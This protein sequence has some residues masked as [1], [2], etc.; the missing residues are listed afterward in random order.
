M[1]GNRALTVH[2]GQRLVG[3]LAETV[4]RRV[5]FA[6]D[7][8]WLKNGF[9]ISPFSLPLEERVFLPVK[10]VFNGLFGVFAD[11]MPDAWGRLLVDRMLQ[12]RGVSPD[13]VSPLERLAI[14]GDSGMGALSYRPAWDIRRDAV[15]PGDLDVLAEAC[16]AVLTH[17]DVRNLDELFQMGGSSGGARPKVM[18]DEWIVKFP[19]AGERSDAGVVEKAYMDCAA[20]CGITVPKTKLMPSRQCGGYF[21][22]RRFDRHRGS[23][24]IMRRVHMLTAAALLEIDWRTPALDYHTLMK[25]TKILCRDDPQDVTQMFRR[26]C[27][28]VFAHNQDDHAKNFTFIYDEASDRWDVSPAYDLTYSSTYFGEHTTTVDGNGKNLGAKELLAVGRKA[29]L[30]ASVC[31]Q[32][33]GEIEEKTRVL[34]RFADG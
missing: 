17:E 25:L 29:G 5:A 15:M 23:D 30:S 14:V 9:S 16:H 6:Y 21:A 24:G 10:P 27:F 28:N 3:T 11:S 20:A 7:R 34:T 22:I 1:S 19:A 18:T 2:T 12:S 32:I 13:A 4:D 8:A 33:A 26:A 31:R